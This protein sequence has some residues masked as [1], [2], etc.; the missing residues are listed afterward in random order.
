MIT[1]AECVATFRYKPGWSAELIPAAGPGV[2][3]PVEGA[4]A[5]LEIKFPTIDSTSHEPLRFPLRHEFP[6]PAEPPADGWDRW[7]FER[8]LDAEH[9]EAMEFYEVNGTRPMYPDH[10]GGPDTIRR[11]LYEIRRRP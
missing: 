4:V 10:G 11:D 5:Y 8:V 1:L 9:H 2:W 7:L 3:W 6:V